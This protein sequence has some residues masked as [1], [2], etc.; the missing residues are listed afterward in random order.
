MDLPYGTFIR[1]L[2]SQGATVEWAKA[3]E[4]PSEPDGVLP[5]VTVTHANA[6]GTRFV[7]PNSAIRSMP[8]DRGRTICDQLKVARDPRL[9][10]VDAESEDPGMQKLLA[11]LDRFKV[12]V[13][14]GPDGKTVT[15]VT[16][17]RAITV[18]RRDGNTF[19][20]INVCNALSLPYP[21]K[22]DAFEERSVDRNVLLEQ[23]RATHPEVRL[24]EL[25]P[26][27]ARADFVI[28]DEFGSERRS[29]VG[30]DSDTMTPSEGARVCQ[31]L[32][33]AQRPAVLGPGS[34]RENNF[35]LTGAAAPAW[36]L[37][38]PTIDNAFKLGYEATRRELQRGPDRPGGEGAT[39]SP[40]EWV[41]TAPAFLV[42][43][44]HND[45]GVDAQGR[46]VI[47]TQEER[48]G[49]VPPGPSEPERP[50]EEGPGH[51]L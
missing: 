12:G 1:Y 33:L 20:I 34:L 49:E 19:S 14:A 3:Q 8:E 45:R 44:H 27:T 22:I 47:Q 46:R 21:L 17:E 26:L 48:R 40:L 51:G 38:G 42:E 24:D 11:H 50:H 30:H 5:L 23:I 36:G 15:F 7:L 37:M 41:R 18:P 13:K 32:N 10:M 35:I 4:D 28:T 16:A 25:E 31:E 43:R 29:S 39:D 2:Q 6:P 9:A